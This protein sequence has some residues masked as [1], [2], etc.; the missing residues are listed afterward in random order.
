MCSVI[1]QTIFEEIGL[2]QLI[3]IYAIIFYISYT[4][5]KKQETHRQLVEDKLDILLAK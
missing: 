2:I 3:F 1:E 5:Y 4:A